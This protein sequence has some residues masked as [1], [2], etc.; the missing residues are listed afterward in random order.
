M[1]K[2]RLQPNWRKIEM[3]TIP[4]AY[5]IETRYTSIDGV[6][7]ECWEDERF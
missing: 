4:R 1:D 6:D 5:R 7:S 3:V 2:L